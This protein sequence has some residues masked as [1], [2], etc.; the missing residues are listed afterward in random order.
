MEKSSE[1]PGLY[2]LSIEER[3][4]VLKDFASLSDDDLKA[5][6]SLESADRMIENVV[7]LFPLPLGIAT[8]F[9]INGKDYLIPIVLEEPSV[10]AAASNAAKMA[11]KKG[12]FHATSDDPVM[13]G[14]I[15][16]TNVKDPFAAKL[17][18]MEAKAEI[19]QKAN[20][21]DP[22][23]VKLGGGAKATEVRVIDAKK[24]MVITHLLVNVKDAM[25][26]NAVN[27]MC[28]AIAPMIERIG[29]GEVSLRILSNLAIHRLARSRAVF[30]KDLLG[31]EKVVERIV[32]AYHFADRDPYRCATHNKGIMNGIDGLAI[33]TGNDFRA[34]EAGAHTFASL[35]GYHS[36]T[37][38][39]INE[40]GDLVGS[41]E[42]PIAC[43]IIGGATSSH[44]VAKLSL[45]ILKVK[46]AQELAQVMASFGLAQN[47][48]ALRALASEGIQKGHMALHSRNIAIMAGAKGEEIDKVAG[49]LVKEG[50]VRVDRARE[51]LEA[52]RKKLSP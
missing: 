25:G 36:L 21:Q 47:L 22:V 40:D 17:R 32:E 27:T 46:S 51:I 1:I 38:Y 10:V 7:A 13:I 42:L 11:R 49:I 12:G 18:I 20:E 24:T 37:H 33:A 41:I 14:Q 34:V 6:L 31:G 4:K 16:L 50:K 39:E 52:I 15:Q 2:R 5:D 9:L 45:K 3:R 28:E 19:L 35:G 48:A 26:A 8:N 23:L 30:D 43:G 29:K 44:P